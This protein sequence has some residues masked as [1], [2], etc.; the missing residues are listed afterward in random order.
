MPP[1]LAD[2]AVPDVHELPLGQVTKLLDRLNAM[3]MQTLEHLFSDAGQ[4]NDVAGRVKTG[5]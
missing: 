3:L 2:D 5:H 4:I 1:K